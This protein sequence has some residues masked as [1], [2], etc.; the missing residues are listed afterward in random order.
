M[1]LLFVL[2]LQGR[3][4]FDPELIHKKILIDQAAMGEVLLRFLQFIPSAPPQG[5][6]SQPGKFQI[7]RTFFQQS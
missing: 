4:G 2:L 5:K 3:H 6:L 1:R 7:K